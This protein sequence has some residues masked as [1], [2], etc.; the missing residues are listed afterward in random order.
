[1]IVLATVTTDSSPLNFLTVNFLLNLQG[2][3]RRM[4]NQIYLKE[5]HTYQINAPSSCKSGVLFSETNISAFSHK[6]KTHFTSTR[7]NTVQLLTYIGRSIQI[8]IMWDSKM[9]GDYAVIVHKTVL[10]KILD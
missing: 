6:K 1:M 5:L 4:L 9:N 3:E 10:E 8:F 2:C 7:G